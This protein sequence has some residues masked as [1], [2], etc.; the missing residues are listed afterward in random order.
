MI[1]GIIHRRGGPLFFALSLV[2]LFLLL[3][4]LRGGEGRGGKS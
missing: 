4:W 2:P 3:W 1:D